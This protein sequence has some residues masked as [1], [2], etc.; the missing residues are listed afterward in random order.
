LRLV[1]KKFKGAGGCSVFKESK[2]EWE[3]RNEQRTMNECAERS[4][5]RHVRKK[6]RKKGEGMEGKN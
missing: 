4:D 1:C 5:V 6:K 2:G 3:G